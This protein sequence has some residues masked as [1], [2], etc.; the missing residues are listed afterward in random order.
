MNVEQIYI[1]ELMDLPPQALTAQSQ[2]NMTPFE[3]YVTKSCA[4][5]K[6]SKNLLNDE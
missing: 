3:W 4:L 2:E 1:K 6:Q 5:Y